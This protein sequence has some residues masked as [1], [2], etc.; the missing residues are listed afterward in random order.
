MNK[1]IIILILV[2]ILVV[3]AVLGIF[4]YYQS[5]RAPK[6]TTIINALNLQLLNVNSNANVNTNLNLNAPI[7]NTPIEPN[8]PLINT[9]NSVTDYQPVDISINNF[10]FNPKQRNVKIGTTVTWTNDDPAPHTVTFDDFTSATLITGQTFSHTFT[11]AGTFNYHCSLHPSM[12][13]QIIVQ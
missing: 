5:G 9:N 2:V 12:T 1:K 3:I 7:V 11:Q 13:G 6:D 10:A 8:T 4:F